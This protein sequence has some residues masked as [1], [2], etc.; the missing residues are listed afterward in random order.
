MSVIKEVQISRLVFDLFIK[1]YDLT[2]IIVGYYNDYSK[3]ELDLNSGYVVL[4]ASYNYRF[5]DIDYPIRETG[6]EEYHDDVCETCKTLEFNS[7]TID[8][9]SSYIEKWE[10][11]PDKIK[12]K[13][14]ERN[15]NRIFENKY[16]ENIISDFE[17]T[18]FGLVYVSYHNNIIVFFKNKISYIENLTT[19]VSVGISENIQ[20]RIELAKNL[21]K[22][23]GD[24][25]CVKYDYSRDKAKY[26]YGEDS[27]DISKLFTHKFS[28]CMSF[29]LDSFVIKKY[30]NKQVVILS[31]DSE[32]G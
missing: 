29:D 27:R 12:S 4:N 24:G 1:N 6:V 8:C 10:K 26:N 28:H 19:G 11:L 32:S 18:M 22:I 25:I 7:E 13:Y 20:K 23:C 9:K 17:N 31:F 16:C 14:I 30:K 2:D 15:F 3:I 5:F 21:H